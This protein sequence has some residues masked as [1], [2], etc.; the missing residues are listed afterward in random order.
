MHSRLSPSAQTVQQ[1]YVFKHHSACCA[2]IVNRSAKTITEEYAYDAAVKQ[3]CVTLYRKQ[4]VQFW[5][6]GNLCKQRKSRNMCN[7]WESN[8]VLSPA[9]VGITYILLPLLHVSK[10]WYFHFGVSTS[11]VIWDYSQNSEVYQD[12][13]THKEAWHNWTKE[14]RLTCPINMTA[15][16]HS[17]S[18]DHAYQSNSSWITHHM[19]VSIGMVTCL[20]WQLCQSCAAHLHAE[21]LI[22]MTLILHW[23]C[24]NSK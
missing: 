1:W 15:C 11:W 16:Q 9:A 13:N 20:V 17:N 6:L 4:H 8:P 10:S 14:R 5:S 18:N 12:L 22:H 19:H 24:T 23:R 7:M 2:C 3:L 21:Q